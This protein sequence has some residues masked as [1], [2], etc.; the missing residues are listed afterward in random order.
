MIKKVK[1]ESNMYREVYEIR[2][3]RK[4]AGLDKKVMGGV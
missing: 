2:L 3:F 1:Y 4:S